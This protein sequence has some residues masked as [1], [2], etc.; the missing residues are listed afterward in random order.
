M[1]QFMGA[2]LT[3]SLLASLPVALPATVRFEK[4]TDHFYRLQLQA[5]GPVVG[6]VITDGGILL[7]NPP[8]QPQLA[9]V[10]SALKVVKSEPLN[11]VVNTDYSYERNGGSS[12]LVRQG[13]AM[14][15]SKEQRS[16]ASRKGETPFAPS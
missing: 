13:A 10:L 1:K 11:W 16:L 8:A 9:D 15:E 2:V 12:E 7:V 6:A 3:L 5:A 4:V 14:L